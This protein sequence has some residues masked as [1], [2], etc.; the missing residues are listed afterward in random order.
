MNIRRSISVLTTGAGLAIL[1]GLALPSD[2]AAHCDSMDGPVV[3][4]ARA[5]LER[6][7]AALA[8]GWVRPSDEAEIRDAFRRTLEV[9]NA[10]GAAAELADRWF[11]ETLVRVHRA[12]EGAP[13]T[14]LKPAGTELSVGIEAA[15]KALRAGTADGLAPRLAEH[16]AEAVRERFERVHALAQHDPADVEATRAYVEAYVGYIHFVEELVAL[17]HGGPAHAAEGGTP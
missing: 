14:G 4:A 11:F 12:G 16:V 10:G 2:A 8:L 17:V 7:D 5:A 15:E 13:F 9:R 3:A 1:A 6:G